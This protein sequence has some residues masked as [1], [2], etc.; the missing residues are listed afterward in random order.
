MD[1]Q[2]MINTMSNDELS[3]QVGMVY[4]VWDDGEI[5]L[6]KCGDLLWQRSIHTINPDLG[7]GK[8]ADINFPHKRGI[9]SYAFVT[10]KD[11]ESIRQA[12]KEYLKVELEIA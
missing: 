6:Q 10:D 11:A 9:Y 8:L 12:M 5:T 2:E 3:K 7:F 4:Q 1:L